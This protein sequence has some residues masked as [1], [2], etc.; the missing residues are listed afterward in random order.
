MTADHRIG[1]IKLLIP[2]IIF[3]YKGWV[4]SNLLLDNL[5]TKRAGGGEHYKPL[6]F[7]I[8]SGGSPYNKI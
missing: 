3:A 1:S 7:H 2:R 4:F 6:H 5:P 8:K